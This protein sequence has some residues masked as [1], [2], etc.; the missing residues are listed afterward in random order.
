MWRH[1]IT[2]SCRSSLSVAGRLAAGLLLLNGVV[3]LIA[4]LSL[5]QSRN[6]HEELAATASRNLAVV[7]DREL[8]ATI[9]KIDLLLL[10][11]ADEQ[12]RIGGL[13]DAQPAMLDRFIERQGSRVPELQ[14]LRT[15]H[16]NGDVERGLGM[17]KGV[18]A[19]VA[20][21]AYFAELA[22]AAD[23][24]L[25]VSEPIRSRVTG[26]WEIVLAR[27]LERND[28]SFD[29]VVCASLPL[30]YFRDKFATLD[31][32]SGGVVAL[33][34]T[35]LSLI[36]RHP[37][38]RSIGEDVGKKDVS[39]ELRTRVLAGSA[40]DTYTAVAAADGVAR[41]ISFRRLGSLPMVVI[42]GLATDDYLAKWRGEATTAAALVGAFCVVSL[43]FAALALRAWKRREDDV[44]ALG[45]QQ[46]KFR[47]LLEA[48]PDALVIVDA[49]LVIAVINRQAEQMFDHAPGMLI[50]QP[51]A[52]MMPQRFRQTYLRWLSS[53]VETPTGTDR[54]HD[55]DR[56]GWAATSTGK[57]FPVG[58][59][60]NPIETEDGNMLAV[61]IRDMS[62]RH[63]SNEQIAF[64]ARHDALTGLPNRGA[65]EAWIAQA[66]AR[67]ERAKSK[68]ALL[69][70]DLDNFK[71][72]NDA[73][74]HAIGDSVLKAV[75]DRLR[76]FARDTDL[77]S[78][79]GSDEFLIALTT[80]ADAEAARAAVERLLAMFESPCQVQGNAVSAMFSL[81]LAL[82]PDDGRDFATLLRKADIAMSEAKAAGRNGYRFFDPRMNT[83]A[84]DHLRLLAD[85]R[86]AIERQELAVHYQPQIELA[87][88]RVIGAEALV[89]W[90][91]P[92]LGSVPPG[93]FIPIAEESGLIV[94]I[95]EWVLRE[96]CRQAV[97][98]QAVGGSAFTIAV[99]LSAVQFR[100]GNLERLVLD[101]LN[102]S[103]LAPANLE[104][105]LTESILI[106]DVDNVLAMV[107]QLQQIGVKLSLDD[108]G[109]GYS[110]LSY[111][112]RFQFDKLKIDQSFVRNLSADR[113]NLPIV[114]AIVRMARALGLT[115]IAEGVENEAAL[116]VLL[117]LRCDE[118]QGYLFARPMP[119]AQLDAYLAKAAGR[120]QPGTWATVHGALAQN[121]L[122]IAIEEEAM[123]W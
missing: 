42:V 61:T 75:A 33:R 15:A 97:R 98:W 9:D 24:R 65:A 51:I 44:A 104:L 92:E 11:V 34:R 52:L 43:L 74:G 79:H 76:E 116:E 115:T 21:H 83:P 99:N 81:G 119:A 8:A 2:D 106:D 27:R 18:R 14:G 53:V 111:L 50:G 123:A 70:F 69:S 23:S 41:T 102:D 32:G 45:V 108:F 12:L 38:L 39:D 101:A 96:A 66:I 67:A 93:R 19:N 1:P 89:R 6:R 22:G 80:I 86:L 26:E 10:T 90:Q 58:I 71:R 35:D 107:R 5:H 30:R 105:E 94:P 72:I 36:A 49:R 4:L 68:V 59:G 29:G 31:V 47:A 40:A 91:H 28:G 63:A 113:E 46:R 17:V 84:D 54:T 16:S 103:G 82:F 73:L 48:S 100:R 56:D 7:L 87:S 117:A 110:S 57:E 114:R 109:T 95:G 37:T 64:L 60:L 3:V 112:K 25:V 55:R 121:A 77:V 120:L 122:E 118:A 78:R 20:N 62:E 13:A 88:G 85:L